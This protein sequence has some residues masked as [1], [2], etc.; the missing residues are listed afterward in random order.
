MPP[1]GAA[2]NR[3]AFR[4]RTAPPAP[5][6]RSPF[7]VFSVSVVIPVEEVTPEFRDAVP[8]FLSLEP[9]AAEI[10]VLPNAAPPKPLPP[11]RYVATGPV[12]PAAKRDAALAAA[13]G[14]IL[15]F[16]DD[17]AYPRRD[18]LGNALRHFADPRV[19]AVGGPALTPPDDGLW[20]HVSGAV[21]QSS[22]GSG[23]ARMRFRPV[24]S[25]RPVDDWPSVNLLVRREV[26]EAVGGFDA[27][28][29][30]GED[31]KLCLDIRR[32][33]KQ[34]LYDPE[35]VVYHHR[36]TTPLRHLRQV[37]RYGLHRGHF[38]RI[39]PE[40]SR[41]TFYFLPSL[42]VVALVTGVVFAAAVPAT[43][44]P[45]G[46]VAALGLIAVAGAGTVEAARA[47]RPAVVFLYP[48]LLLATHVTYGLAFLR[49]L[50]S[51][52]LKR[53]ARGAR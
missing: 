8:K 6:G 38:A 17:D 5:G 51:P 21:L 2:S 3:V 53:Y 15:A 43:S 16:I 39:F 52:S 12:G 29:W 25:V 30:P 23:G 19:A 1:E 7:A 41:R 26:F 44:V 37:A 13:R 47:R 20:A 22:V 14:D 24:G 33:Q 36:A 4:Q 45:L 40:T 11:V 42:F 32:L 46:A 50:S 27:A 10:I 48:L 34:M 9:P 18:W 28:Y 31:T 35:A 49:G